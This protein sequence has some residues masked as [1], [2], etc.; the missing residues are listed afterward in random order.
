MIVT[1]IVVC[2]IA[3]WLLLAGGLALRY[4]ARMPRT[5]AAVLLC[6]PVLELVLLVATAVDLKNGAQPDWKHGLAAVYVG[7]SVGLGRHTV[8]RVDA[9]VAHRF[10]GG[11]K[12]SRPPAGGPERTR[13]EWQAAGRW[14][15]AAAV[16][17]A[18]LQGAAWYVGGDAADP[19]RTWRQRMLWVIGINLVIALSYTFFPKAAP[20]ASEPSRG[21]GSDEPAPRR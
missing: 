18:L 12:P 5:G 19:L 7:F 17:I 3:F 13:Y 15:L 1:L 9:H 21:A 16:A 14:I 2:E 20:K 8:R 4:P 6:E 10:A 11:P